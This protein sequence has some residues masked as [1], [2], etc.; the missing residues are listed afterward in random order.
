MKK[1]GFQENYTP[2]TFNTDKNAVPQNVATIQQIQTDLNQTHTKLQ[3][4][5]KTLTTD[6]NKNKAYL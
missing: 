5:Y 6:V 2:M 3:K 1:R 4:N